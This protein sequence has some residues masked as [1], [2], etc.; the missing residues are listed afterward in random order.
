MNNSIKSYNDA[1]AQ[2]GC[3]ICRRDTGQIVPADLHHIAEGSS[4]RSEFMK[5]PL[6]KEHHQNGPLSLH[7][8]GVKAF[9]RMSVKY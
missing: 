6:C 5:A 1:I 3:V 8:A 4:Q 7:G 2:L 9:L